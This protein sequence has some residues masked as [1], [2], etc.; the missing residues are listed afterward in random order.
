MNDNIIISTISKIYFII[1][2]FLLFIFLTLSVTFIILQNGLYIDNISL[3]NLKIKQLYIKWNEKLNI[4]VK[5][6]IIIDSEKKSNSKINQKSIDKA[7]H[8]MSNIYKLFEKISIEKII[9]KDFVGSFKYLDDRD[10]YFVAI[11]PTID[12]KTTLSFNKN[13]LNIKIEKFNDINRDIKLHGNIIICGTSNDITTS[14]KVN[15]HDDIFV[16]VLANINKEKFFY[17]I[18]SPKNIKSITHTMELLNLHEAVKYW[19][20]KAID[21]SSVS[22]ENIYGWGEFKNLDNAYKNLYA[23]L[24]GHDLTYTY[25]KNLDSIHSKNTKVVFKE[26]VLYINPHLPRSYNSDLGKSWLKIDFTKKEELLTLYLLFDGQLDKETLGVLKQYKINVPFL[27]NTG[28]TKTN[29]TLTVNLRTIYVTAKGEF[30][31][32]KANFRYQGFDIDVFDAY[33]LLDNYDVEINNMLAKYQDIATTDVDVKFNAKNKA[34]TIDLNIKK[35][36]FNDIGVSLDTAKAPLKTTYTLSAKQDKIDIGKSS[37]KIK[38]HKVDIDKITLPFNLNTLKINIPSTRISLKETIKA[39]ISGVA[40]FKNNIHNLDIDLNKLSLGNL[41]LTQSS[42]PLHLK[43]QDNLSIN[44]NKVI[45]FK[46]NNIESFLGKASLK[47][48]NHTISTENLYINIGN[49]L[50]TK[51]CADYNTD[52]QTGHIKTKSIKL[53]DEN[54]KTLYLSN[55][56]I[57]FD[58]SK[59]KDEVS[60]KSKQLDLSFLSNSDMW[61]LKLDSIVNVAKDSQL[62]QKYKVVNG[63][64]SFQKKEND[65]YIYFNSNIKYPYKLLV[66]NNAEIEDYVINGKINSENKKISLNINK[67]VDIVIDKDIEI[68]MK[69][70]GINT[71]TIVDLID[72]FSEDSNQTDSTKNVNIEAKN[73]YLYISKDRRVISQDMYLQY[74]KKTLTAQLKYKKG[75]A[76]LKYENH[77]FYAYGEDFNDKFME[78]LFSLS[79]FKGGDFEFRISGSPTEYD[80]IF[81]V[82]DTIIIDYKILNNILAFVN[83]IPSLV[84]FA[85]PG[86]STKGL[87]ADKAYIKFNSK[88]N[89]FNISDIYLDS[90]EVDILGNGTVSI[91]N[92]STDLELNLKSDIGSKI[93]K[94]PVIGYLLMDK[95]SIS[96]TLSI[97]GSLTDPK[98]KSLLAKDI[99]VAPLNI[100]MRTISLPYNLIKSFDN[101]DTK[102]KE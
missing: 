52:K 28:S 42:T 30:F 15:I 47:L 63:E 23:S 101:N 91:K 33:I 27:Q 54:Q 18:N 5:E 6:S 49:T 72:N 41:E 17:K 94:I 31:T 50:K 75:L 48:K 78:N 29:L 80:G 84:T 95:D 3:P 96:T 71:N 22:V 43:Y 9:Y 98:I 51:F 20:Y 35:I 2:S 40:D 89:I 67:L 66:K 79:K 88:N 4:S 38:N 24:N 8:T 46:I 92:N 68:S 13:S 53:I 77:H 64:I 76:D 97:T 73:S 82:N 61:K 14:I 69:D 25:N 34:G 87:K 102:D 12:F 19:A 58:I 74:Y 59:D 81:T 32:K 37:W 85:L 45:K 7:F 26:G 83:T 44:S 86:Y 55:N 39:N 70:I 93:S 65:K 57:N 11:S 99:A 10:G 21:F 16:E 100:L 60:I 36:N 56:N 90:K 1:T 62:L